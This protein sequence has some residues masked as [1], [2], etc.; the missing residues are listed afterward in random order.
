MER[1]YVLD[2]TDQT[3]RD[4]FIAHKV[5]ITAS[6]YLKNGNS[7]AKRMR[8]FWE[9]DDNPTV[10]RV[11]NGLIDV[12]LQEKWLEESNPLIEEG[13]KIARR[14]MGNQAV[15]EQDLFK[16]TSDSS[17]FKLLAEEIRDLIEKQKFQEGLDRLHIF[18]MKFIKERC[19]SYGIDVTRDKP[20]HSVFG[21]YVKALREAGHI[22]SKM[23]EF[24]LK[25]SISVLD[26]FNEVRNNKSFAHDNPLLNYEESLLIF[27]YIASLIRFINSLENKIKAKVKHEEGKKIIQL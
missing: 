18:L 1:G 7:K 8:M 5:D 22:E 26:K 13:R 21:E 3:Y 17:D 4:F 24:I 11:M 25:T 2:F 16:V 14:L 23:T 12:G 6:K 10:G 20:L 19:K 15:V 9:L 27:N